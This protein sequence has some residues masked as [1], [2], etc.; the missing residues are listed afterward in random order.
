MN[1]SEPYTLF[2]TEKFLIYVMFHYAAGWD[3]LLKICVIPKH[4]DKESIAKS[5]GG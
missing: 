5:D 4:T 3:E 1:V 2:S